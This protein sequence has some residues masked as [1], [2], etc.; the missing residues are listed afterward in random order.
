MSRRTA[1]LAGGACAA[2]AALAAAG[3]LTSRRALPGGRVQVFF[4]SQI[5]GAI[6]PCGC[7]Q[8]QTGG[9]PRRATALRQKRLPGDST[10]LVDS[11]NFVGQRFRLQEFGFSD[12]YPFQEM[13]NVAL[14]RGLREMGYDAVNVGELDFMLGQLFLK[15]IER[16]MG[17]P[18]VSANVVYANA[19]TPAPGEAPK[20]KR[21]F[22]ALV[23]RTIGRG[24]FLGVPFGGIRVG[25]FGL[26]PKHAQLKYDRPAAHQ[27]DPNPLGWAEPDDAA[28][29]AVAELR[30][31]G[32]DLVICAAR[33]F[34]PEATELARKVPGMD[35]IVAGREYRAPNEPV[36]SGT[37]V[38]V[39]AEPE[40]R[41]LGEV[42][43]V[44]SEGSPVRVEK[45][46]NHRLDAGFADDAGQKEILARFRQEL[47]EKRIVPDR[48][49]PMDGAYVGSAACAGC[50]AE[51]QEQWR[52]VATPPGKHDDLPF[53][54]RHAH[55]IESLQA[56]GEAWNP[57]CLPCH[58]L[59]YAR[60]G[61]FRSLADT[62]ERAEVGCESCHGPRSAHVAYQKFLSGAPDAPKEPPPKPP[63]P[64]EIRAETCVACHDRANSPGFKFWD[65]EQRIRH[66]AVQRKLDAKRA[67]DARPPDGASP[68]KSG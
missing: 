48:T 18:L 36:Y 25:I 26:V 56:Q 57:A 59:G 50:H 28:A 68:P 6:A 55:A 65:Y 62:T 37:T 22:P 12:P 53:G 17:L 63:P 9:N 13:H 38:I 5:G 43:L 46:G 51:E 27:Q 64:R 29:E 61:G 33:L 35:L 4:T 34:V 2:L 66:P 23:V 31:E 19:P 30:R 44:L 49:I 47:E 42:V 24:S 41:T 3:F 32:C 21:V 10:V 20:R 14:A 11:G 58:T 40:G 60:P 52:R 45:L 67:A 16:E 54:K 1:A 8:A 15:R 7:A 39:A